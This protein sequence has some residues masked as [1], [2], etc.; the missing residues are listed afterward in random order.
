M[1]VPSSVL[2]K[3]PKDVLI[4]LIETIQ[5]KQKLENKMLKDYIIELAQYSDK[6]VRKCANNEC[7]HLST[8][9][10]QTCGG[11]GRQCVRCK[12]Y[13]CVYHLCDSKLHMLVHKNDKTFNCGPICDDC[14]DTYT[15]PDNFNFIEDF[16]KVPV[17]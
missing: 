9:K 14:Y 6:K 11:N 10:F 4:Y 5:T 8:W 7:D 3:L 13:W 2:N 15:S 12:R 17:S 1:S 16:E